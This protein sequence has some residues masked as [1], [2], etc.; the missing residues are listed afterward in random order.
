MV[1]AC[2][3]E[4]ASIDYLN[5]PFLIFNPLLYIHIQAPTTPVDPSRPSPLPQLPPT[6]PQTS[7]IINMTTPSGLSSWN[8]SNPTKRAR[9]R[10][11]EADQGPSKK[12]ET[13]NSFFEIDSKKLTFF[14]ATLEASCLRSRRIQDLDLKK[15][16]QQCRLLQPRRHH[17][18]PP[19][20]LNRHTLRRLPMKKNPPDIAASRQVRV[21]AVRTRNKSST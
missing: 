14:Q 5:L 13:A 20:S 8:Q 7:K 21:L 2:V 17:R 19:L 1:W 3:L 15:V 9:S 18:V 11:H 4:P 10:E 16:A 12:R 6:R